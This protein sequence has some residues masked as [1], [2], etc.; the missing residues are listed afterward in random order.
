MQSPKNEMKWVCNE[1][2]LRELMD[3]YP[4]SWQRVGPQL[5]S[6]LEDGRSDTLKDYSAKA[7]SKEEMWQ[8]KIRQS[9]FSDKIIQSALPHLIESRM[10]LLAMDQCYQAAATGKAS[11][12]IRFNRINGYIIQKLLFSHH[13]TRKP[14]MLKWFRFWWPFVGQKRLLMPL[15]QPKGIYCFYSK[16]LIEQLRILIGDRSCLEIAAGDGTLTRFLSEKGM[17]IQAT[18]DHSWS[19]TVE[20]PETVERIGAKQALVKYEPKAVICSWPP[21]GNSFEHR[22]FSTRSVEIY[23]VIGSRHR[24]S[25]G[26]WDSYEAQDRFEWCLDPR[27][28]SLIIPPELDSAALVFKRKPS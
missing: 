4:E 10:A 13:L 28:S 20:F 9:R 19:H 8:Y 22:V 23:V 1:A 2:R 6:R 3:R 15:V 25:A 14:A 24:F 16:E 7:K 17:R 21:P 27:L 12:K 26:N 5:V 18:D 11:G